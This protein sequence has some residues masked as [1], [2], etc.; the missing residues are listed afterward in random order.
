MKVEITTQKKSDG[1]GFKIFAIFMI[2][3]CFIQVWPL[4]IIYFSEYLKSGERRHFYISLACIAMFPFWVI[5][6]FN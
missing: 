4:I 2:V 3:N 6:L 1:I 5:A